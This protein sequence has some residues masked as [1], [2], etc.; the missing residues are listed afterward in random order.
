MTD[1]DAPSTPPSP[2]AEDDPRALFARAVS[3][4]HTTID[5]VTTER[6]HD[7]T[8]AGM[9]V[10]DLME[11]LVMVLRRV[12]CAGRGQPVSTW[13]VDATDVAND[14]FADAWREAAHDVQAAWTDDGLLDRAVDL[15]WGSF[16]GAEV[17][18]SYTNEVTVHTWDLAKATDQE[19]SW[20]DAVLAAAD[21]SIRAQLP[22]AVRS[23]I[24]EAAKTQLPEGMPWETPFADAVEV[25]GDAPAIDRLIAWNGRQP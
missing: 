17:L 14:G 13:P 12:A 16:T 6:L 8:P 5:H 18:G 22:L 20:D 7:P 21:A 9:N 10:R 23:P 3:L 11:H 15:P 2:L 19:P 4:A 24:W 25:R 1:D